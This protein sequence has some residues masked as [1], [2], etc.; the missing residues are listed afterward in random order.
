V[1]D[2]KKDGY[3]DILLAIVQASS[4]KR[5]INILKSASLSLRRI[6][7]SSESLLNWY[8]LAG[9]KKEKEA[10]QSLAIGLININSTYIDID[11]IEKGRLTFT[12]AFSYLTKDL[13]A[14]DTIGEIRRSI[15]TFQRERKT[16]MG[17][18]YVT[19][20]SLLTDKIALALK[21]EIDLPIELIDQFEGIKIEDDHGV[22]SGNA[23]FAGLIG[24]ATKG[25]EMDINLLPESMIIE[26]QMVVLKKE[27]FTSFVLILCMIL[28]LAGIAAK[29]IYDKSLYV[30]LLNEK[31]DLMEPKVRKARKMRDDIRIIKDVI[32]KKPLAIDV[33]SEIYKVT[34]ESINYNLMDYE[35]DR[36]LTLRGNAS[37]LDNVIKFMSVLENSGYFEN[38]KIKYTAKR[39]VGGK[40]VT[41]FEIAA[42]LNKAD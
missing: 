24:L 27:L 33:L 36:S 2:K 3:A 9:Y 15:D 21:R 37:S 29:K 17:K 39:T 26:D 32:Q 8:S 23:S 19:G 34:P 42:S 4:I 10:E 7:L 22:D 31:I 40:Q 11:M 38:V 1:L 13:C 25:A 14:E 35:V 30:K 28:G 12:R 5:F 41:D 18:L 20:P 16:G 6:A